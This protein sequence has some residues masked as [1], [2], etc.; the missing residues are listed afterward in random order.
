ML[1]FKLYLWKVSW[2]EPYWGSCKN[3]LFEICDVVAVG[4]N[5]STAW[6][7]LGGSAAASNIVDVVARDVEGRVGGVVEFDPF[8]VGAVGDEFVDKDVAWAIR[9]GGL[10]QTR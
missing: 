8:T 2:I 4:G 3:P 5:D 7:S 6:D 1:D 9:I 10:G